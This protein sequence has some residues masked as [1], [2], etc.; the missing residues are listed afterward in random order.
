M[1][2]NKETILYLVYWEDRHWGMGCQIFKDLGKA[3]AWAKKEATDCCSHKEDLAEGEVQPQG[4]C[5]YK[6]DYSREGD[7]LWI[8][9]AKVKF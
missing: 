6:I 3:K 5:L 1:E 7:C 9:A 4:D 8:E 2:L